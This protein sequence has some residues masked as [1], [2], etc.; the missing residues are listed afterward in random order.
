MSTVKIN[1]GSSRMDLQWSGSLMTH[2]FCQSAL[3]IAFRHYPVGVLHD[4]LQLD[5]DISEWKLTVRFKVNKLSLSFA[6]SFYLFIANRIS[7][8]MK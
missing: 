4:L 6:K 5:G 1:C 7:Q 8:K 2:C 3:I